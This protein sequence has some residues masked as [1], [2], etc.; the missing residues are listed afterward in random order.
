MFEGL[1]HQQHD[2]ELDSNI[3]GLDQ[4]GNEK[5]PRSTLTN[6]ARQLLFPPL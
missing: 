6:K 1:Y 2:V 5:L 4:E 3:S